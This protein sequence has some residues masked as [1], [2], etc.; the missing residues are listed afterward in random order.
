LFVQQGLDGLDVTSARRRRERHPV[1][2]VLYKMAYAV[3][4]DGKRLTEAGG[5]TATSEKIKIVDDR[6]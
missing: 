2:K 4:S 3:S 6:Q 5:A 1:G